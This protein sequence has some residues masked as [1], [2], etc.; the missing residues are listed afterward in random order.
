MLPSIKTLYKIGPGPSSSHTIG[1]YKAARDFLKESRKINEDIVKFSVVLY[2]SLACTGKGH[3]TDRIIKK[4]FDGMDIDIQF[5]TE[6][7]KE[8]PNVMAFSSFDSNGKKLLS[9]EYNSVGGGDVTKQ[10][11]YLESREDIYPFDNFKQMR[12]YMEKE[13]VSVR[14]LVSKFEGED[15]F[16]FLEKVLK[17]MLKL[18]KKGLNQTGD[19]AGE[20]HVKR[21]AKDTFI[22]AETLSENELGKNHLYLASYAYAANECNCAGEKVVTCPTCGACG[23]LTGLM[24]Y[25]KHNLNRDIDTLL[26]GLALAGIIGLIVRKNASISGAE[27]GCQAEVGT[28]TSMA[29]GAMCLMDGLSLYQIEYAAEIGMEHSLGLTCDPVKGYVAIPC[30]ERN[31]MGIF[32]AVDSYTLSKNISK[33]RKNTISFDEAVEAMYESG[34]AMHEDFK[35]TSKGGLAKVHIC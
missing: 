14:E 35:E 29:A 16:P 22:Q 2:G 23:V 5:E 15:I 7:K 11:E 33:F 13:N 19:V 26:D 8:H 4:V 10:N 12:E 1:P 21:M 17:R 28:A 34:K 24:Y 32:K 27:A 30:I 3:S 9:L 25:E 6:T 31:V 18:V 20:L